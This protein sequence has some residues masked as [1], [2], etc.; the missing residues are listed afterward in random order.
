MLTFLLT[1]YRKSPNAVAVGLLLF[2]VLKFQIFVSSMGQNDKVSIHKREEQIKLPF[3][4][5]LNVQNSGPGSCLDY[6]F[7]VCVRQKDLVEIE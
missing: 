2:D 6:Q 1:F 3:I 7:N 5:W 4:S